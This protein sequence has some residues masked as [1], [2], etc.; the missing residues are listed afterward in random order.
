[1]AKKQTRRSIS[2][3]RE[4]YEQLKVFSHALGTPMS[5]LTERCLRSYIESQ[6]DPASNILVPAKLPPDIAHVLGVPN[7]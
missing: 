7:G 1:M 2:I 3:N 4:L 6:R 5:Q